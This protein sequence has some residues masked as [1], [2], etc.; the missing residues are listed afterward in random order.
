MAQIKKGEA[1]IKR[2]ELLQQT[3]SSYIAQYRVPFHQL[4]IPYHRIQGGKKGSSYSEEQDRFLL[5]KVNEID[6]VAYESLQ[7]EIVERTKKV[8]IN[9]LPTTNRGTKEAT[10]K[11][12]SKVCENEI[13]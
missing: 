4:K 5:C 10:M 3:L 12:V 2:R 13:L 9:T 6:S 8:A 11:G 7:N 1:K